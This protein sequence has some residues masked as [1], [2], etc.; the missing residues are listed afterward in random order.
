MSVTVL[1]SGDTLTPARAP[2]GSTIEA[3]AVD[4][5]VVLG[6]A[7][8][9]T[10]APAASFASEIVMVPPVATSAPLNVN[11]SVGAG[12]VTLPRQK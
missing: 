10:S 9:V 8:T 6:V 11:F 2:K 12:G 3:E 1:P 7:E 5:S 4:K